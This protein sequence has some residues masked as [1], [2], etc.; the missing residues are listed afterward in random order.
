[1]ILM[2]SSFLC[3]ENDERG[4]HSEGAPHSLPMVVCIL[5]QLSLLALADTTYS[6]TYLLIKFT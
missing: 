6:L 1:M 3:A 5:T 2:S 4:K